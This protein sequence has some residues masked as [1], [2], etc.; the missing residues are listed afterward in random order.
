MNKLSGGT[1]VGLLAWGLLSC[2]SV[3]D[4]V[5]E[6]A[7]TEVF[8]TF[9][10][11]AEATLEV[12]VEPVGDVPLTFTLV[13]PEAET[14][15]VRLEWSD[16]GDNWSDLTVT[17]ELFELASSSTGVDHTVTWDTVSDLGSGQHED[18][19]MRLRVSSACGSTAAGHD[20]QAEDTSR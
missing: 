5:D 17:G 3:D 4:K 12:P 19:Q 16:D 7:D 10:T 14:A 9:C 11:G 6:P 15:Q 20:P 18:L 1:L 13:H 8:G 2:G